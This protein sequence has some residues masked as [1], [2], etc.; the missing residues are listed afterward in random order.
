MSINDA[1]WT[2]A[3][4]ILASSITC[5]LLLTPV[6]FHDE[7][8][9]NFSFL[10]PPLLLLQEFFIAWG[11]GINLWTK[12][13]VLLWILTFSCNMVFVIMWFRILHTHSGGFI[14]FQNT[15]KFCLVFVRSATPTIFHNF[16][17]HSRSHWC[18]Q[19]LT[20]V[21]DGILEFLVLPVDEIDPSQFSCV[22]QMEPFIRPL[23]H[24][25]ELGVLSHWFLELWP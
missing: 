9:S 20:R 3:P 4:D 14:G 24:L 22:I 11:I 15:R 12:I 23:L 25:L 10:C 19:L 5:F 18:F 17:G 6:R 21:L 1:K 2:V 8:F 13:V 16:T 7:I